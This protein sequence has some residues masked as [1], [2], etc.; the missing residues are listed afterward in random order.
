MFLGQYE[1]TLDAKGRVV[2]PRKFRD[3]L[4]EGLVI[5]KGQEHCLYVFPLDRWDEEMTRVSRLPRT[6]IKA[7]NYARSFFAAATDQTLDK[8]GRIQLPEPLRSY[9]SLNKDVT[10]VGVAERIELWST[11]EW[12]TVQAEAD[13]YY[14]GIEEV[15]TEEGDI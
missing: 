15:L 12:E 3:L 8:A 11:S 10:I 7:R 6:N 9:A 14:A 4:A 1:H 5:T 2:M 13:E